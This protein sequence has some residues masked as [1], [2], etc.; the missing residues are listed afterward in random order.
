M[1]EYRNGR[2][3]PEPLGAG[4][5]PVNA[6]KGGTCMERLKTVVWL[7]IGTCFLRGVFVFDM[8]GSAKGTYPIAS[9]LCMAGAVI[10]AA[11]MYLAEKREA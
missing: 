6:R 9:G 11:I 3:Q 10:A 8:G 2:R 4:V 1:A 5:G 7:A